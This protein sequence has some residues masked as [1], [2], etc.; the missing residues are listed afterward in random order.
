MH[1]I[2]PKKPAIHCPVT[3]TCWL[4]NSLLFVTVH[5]NLINISYNLYS[6]LLIWMD[7]FS[8]WR[9]EDIVYPKYVHQNITNHDECSKSIFRIQRKSLLFSCMQ[10]KTCLFPYDYPLPCICTII[11]SQSD[12]QHLHDSMTHEPTGM[13]NW[14]CTVVLSRRRSQTSF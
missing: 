13:R 6:G 8:V 10:V 2:V 5:G 9:C 4:W 1:I 12:V 3:V 14:S 11:V 7:I